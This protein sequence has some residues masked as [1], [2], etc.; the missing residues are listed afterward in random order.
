MRLIHT[1]D[2]HLGHRLGAHDRSAEHAAFLSW[3]LGVLEEEQAHALLIS[4]DVF[5]RGNPPADALARFYSFVADARARVSG[6]QIVVIG[7]NHDAP[8][9]IDAPAPILEA[10]GVRVLGALPR[11]AGGAVSIERACMELRGASG[12]VEALACLV[13]FVRAVDTLG[14]AD[15]DAVCAHML[16]EAA[17]RRP[18]GAALVALAHGEVE[19]AAL[20]PDSERRVVGTGLQASTL[21]RA[22]YAALGHLHFAQSVGGFA[23]VRYAGSPIPL[24]MAERDYQHAVTV[25]D[26]EGAALVSTRAR[27]VPRL[28]EL[29]RIGDGEAPVDAVLTALTE[30]C[31]EA[32][33]EALRPLVDVR[34]KVDGPEPDLR[35]RIE[36]ALA[37]KPVR[38]V[39]VQALRADASTHAHA[40]EALLDAT[41]DAVLEQ[42]YRAHH[43]APLPEALRTAFGVIME[44]LERER[45]RGEV[46]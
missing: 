9:R 19:G 32:R 36:R 14:F 33:P 16:D 3:L 39:R 21:A 13:P 46:S 34:V 24:S 6:L 20:T 10:L 45:E 30:L 11:D 7:G 15:A 40:P 8:S 2:W 27:A 29:L 17:A 12:D 18:T 35:G 28:V 22:T 1:A 44:D 5:D 4:G 31:V 38:L 43:H 42:L 37:D 25:V 23:H 41:P 26:L